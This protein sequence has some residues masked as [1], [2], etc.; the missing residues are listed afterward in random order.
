MTVCFTNDIDRT[1][2]ETSKGSIWSQRKKML[3][4]CIKIRHSLVKC[5]EKQ[6]K[7]YKITKLRNRNLVKWDM[8]I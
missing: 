4:I 3:K 6:Q 7:I 1:N 2:D 5:Y 8:V